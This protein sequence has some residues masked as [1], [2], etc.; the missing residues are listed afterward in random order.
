MQ[1]VA[2]ADDHG[3][4]GTAAILPDV[5][6]ATL[7]ERAYASLLKAI[8][9]GDLPP[10]YRLRDHELAAQLGVSRT[11]VREALRRLEDEG[12]VESARN[13]F[14]R[15]AP[16]R[17]DRIADAFPVVAALHG[18]GARLGVPALTKGDIARMERHDTERTAA[19]R[20]GD[21]LAA[22]AEDDRLHGV[23]LT[24]ARNREIERL[25]ARVMPHIRRLDIIHFT[26]LTE[27]ADLD[28]GHTAIIDA[29]RRGEAWEA[30]RLVEESFLRLGEH[31][32]AVL[33]A[34]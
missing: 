5:S 3:V 19:L 31:M 23:L 29:C 14:T 27:R 6:Q 25:L 30:G 20:R 17:P 22:I 18:L 28:D 24:A 12:L 13:S 2:M 32:T 9:R 15:V 26:A 33:E 7:A 11:P 4:M 16:V 21:V 8:V 34:G 1:G 10:G